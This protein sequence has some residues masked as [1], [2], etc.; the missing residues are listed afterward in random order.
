MIQQEILGK[1]N[2]DI[3]ELIEFSH[4]VDAFSESI[5]KRV[6]ALEQK[7]EIIVEAQRT[8]NKEVQ[9]MK[10]ARDDVDEIFGKAKE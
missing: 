4:V 3:Q 10:S 1:I 6:I 8:L 5:V 7:L 2:K 9:I